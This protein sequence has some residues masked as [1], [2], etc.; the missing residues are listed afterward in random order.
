M[1]IIRNNKVL[2]LLVINMRKLEK[3]EKERMGWLIL[4]EKSIREIWNNKKDDEIWSK[5]LEC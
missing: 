4:V 1:V 5:Y 3:N 2:R